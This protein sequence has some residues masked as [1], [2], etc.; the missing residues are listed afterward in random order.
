MS[1]G[2]AA[3]VIFVLYLIDKNRQWKAAARVAA[4]LLVLAIVGIGGVIG[5]GKYHAWQAVRAASAKRAE[6]VKACV[7]RNA[8]IDSTADATT[9]QPDH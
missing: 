3:V 8:K 6:V 5:L 2:I 1:L 7:D 9:R 4:V